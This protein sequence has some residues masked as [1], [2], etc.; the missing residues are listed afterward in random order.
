MTESYFVPGRINLIGEHTDY[1]E[2]LALPFA[3]DLGVTVEVH[4]R[5]D[6]QTWIHLDGGRAERIDVT[7]SSE[8]SI[9]MAAAVCRRAPRGGVTLEV[10]STLPDGAGLSSSAAYLGALAL[11]LGVRGDLLSMARF[12]QACEADV[13]SNVGLL[14]QIATL[15]GIA[16]AATLIN[17]ADLTTEH[18]PLPS[19]W[20]FTVMHSEVERVLSHTGYAERRMECQQIIERVGSWSTIDSASIRSLPAPLQARARH[21]VSENQRVHDFLVAMH[22]DDIVWAGQLLTQSHASLRDDFDVSLPAIDSLVETVT[23]LSGV[24]GVR[25]MGGGFGGC[26]LALHDAGVD[27]SLPGHRTWSVEPSRGALTRLM[28]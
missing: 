27:I 3:I 8:L 13:G 28:D 22:T 15:G 9:R 16:H 18:H 7:D 20:R 25:L 14:D 23:S 19:S 11:A 5:T 6:S 1:N 24:H 10:T 26:L 12:V 21:V 4:G 17:F 2:G